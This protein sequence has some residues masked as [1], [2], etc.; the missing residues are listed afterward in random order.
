ME[1]TAQNV[2][3]WV[4]SCKLSMIVASVRWCN[5]AP[6]EKRGWETDR[7]K[8]YNDDSAGDGDSRQHAMGDGVWF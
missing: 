2:V 6:C 7:S 8:T 4:K 5:K 3:K 1:Q